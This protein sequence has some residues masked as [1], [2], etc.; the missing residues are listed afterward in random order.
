MSYSAPSTL[1][2]P[3]WL[4]VHHDKRTNVIVHPVSLGAK[5]SDVDL[6]KLES[7]DRLMR[8]LL[9]AGSG[10]FESPRRHRQVHAGD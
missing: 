4:Y 10:L 2:F 7:W 8:T 6:N 1:M 5:A 3:N 9:A